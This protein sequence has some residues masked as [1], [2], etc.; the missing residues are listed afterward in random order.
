MLQYIHLLNVSSTI[1]TKNSLIYMGNFSWCTVKTHLTT[2]PKLRPLCYYDHYFLVQNF[3]SNSMVVCSGITTTLLF[4][5]CDL[6]NK[7]VLTNICWWDV[8]SNMTA[9]TGGTFYKPSIQI[10]IVNLWNCDKYKSCVMHYTT[11]KY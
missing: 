8:F 3:N 5:R 4:H 7:F 2:T 11:T 6:S 10:Y 1:F 9:Q